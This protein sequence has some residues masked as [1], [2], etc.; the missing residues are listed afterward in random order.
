MSKSQR[1][2]W[3]N[4]AILCD[5][6]RK[7]P[8]DRILLALITGSIPALATSAHAANPAI[9]IS[10]NA[11]ANKKP[12]N[13]NV[14]G[15]AYGTAA[16][17]ADMNVPLNRLGGNNTSRYNWQLNADNRGMDWYFESIGDTSA[18][19][20]ERGDTFIQSSKSAGAQAM[21]TIPMVGYVAKLGTG[22]AKLSS[23]SIKKYGA[24]TGSDAQWFPD[25]GNGVSAA[26]GN[27]NITGNNP[28]DANVAA[29]SVFQQAWIQ[30]IVT[31]WGTAANGGLKYYLMDNEPS[32]WFSTHRDVHPAGPKMDEILAKILDYG[33]KV[34]AVDPS[35]L[36][37]GPEEWGW[38]GYLYSGYDQQY[39]AQHGW[40]LHPDRDAHGGMDYLP[41]LLQQL[42]K[43]NV[44]TGKRILDVFTVHC[45]PQGGEF[46]NDT[47]TAMQL[48]RNR[49]TRQ[50]WDPTYVDQSWINTPVNLVPRLKSW[51]NQYYPGTKIGITEYS[52]GADSHINGATAQADILGILGREGVDMAARWVAP[53]AGT[54]AYN[55]F[56][57]YRNYDGAKSV[58]GD[59]S[60]Q[61]TVPD[62]DTVSSFA[63]TRTSD[64]ALTVTIINKTLSG[65]T[66]VSL[67]V[68]GFTGNQVAQVYQLRATNTIQRLADL[69]VSSGNVLSITVPQQ[70][71]TTVVMPKS[72]TPVTPPAVPSHVA[73]TPGNTVVNLTWDVSPGAMYYDIYRSVAGGAY[74][75]LT[76][77]T[78]NSYS[79][80]QLT[81][82]ALY[83]YKLCAGNL[84]GKSA[85]STPVSATPKIVPTDASKYNFESS[86]QGW[87]TDG[88]ILTGATIA[89]AQ[90]FAGTHSL[91]INIASPASGG[92]NYCSVATPAVPVGQ[93][94][95]FHVWI[96][97][98]STISSIQPYA[99]QGASG[100][101][102][103][104]GSWTGIASL[105]TNAW[106]TI[107][108]TVPA[109]AAVP[110]YALG[111]EVTT[112]GAW[113][114]TAYID[115]VNW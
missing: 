17:L 41:W 109:S 70:S 74:A 82:G 67:T 13:P 47:S 36:V 53:T 54:P 12:I 63:A 89:T 76:R 39:G 102:A 66:P 44:A 60:V 97:A 86:V 7:I 19:A 24:Q 96:P 95:T 50:L 81:N 107:T 93:T 77:V 115:A 16:T 114:G 3:S 113:T 103:W 85:F 84:G 33:G 75:L 21:I 79:N 90:A 105:K 112:T 22:R 6:Y 4:I 5:C 10:V 101:W 34:K 45:Y 27:P 64:G 1:I 62:P 83:S 111:V 71:I 94:V 98:G 61:D 91:A 23:F 46:G 104:T 99:L 56:K 14:Y 35:A 80:S 78:A 52:W 11:T 29:N 68:T 48:L 31:K 88:G 9:T 87:S 15:V 49:S 58:F 40:N 32:I 65:D 92:T 28:L 37:V 51:V 42:S 43:N 38:S 55:A 100:G 73:A 25:A 110:L 20:G 108:V 59:V 106:N 30:H 72:G 69:Q 26:A 8:R 18:V 57:M 2:R